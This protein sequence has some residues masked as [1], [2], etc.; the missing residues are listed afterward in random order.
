[1]NACER[2]PY[3]SAYSKARGFTDLTRQALALVA[4]VGEPYARLLRLLAD[5]YYVASEADPVLYRAQHQGASYKQLAYIAH[6]AGLSPEERR[7]WYRIAQSVPLAGR[8]AGH[9]IA[10]L[11]KG[12]AA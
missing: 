3:E 4:E 5:C 11:Q 10:R 1:M 7:Q 6:L 9:I 12:Q 8:H 2:I